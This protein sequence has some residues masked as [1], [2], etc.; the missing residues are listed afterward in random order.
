M[1]PQIFDNIKNLRELKNYTQQYMAEK[2]SITQAGYNKI[3]KGKTRLTFDKL[4]EISEIL[5]VNIVDTIS[6]DSQ[7]YFNSSNKV[8][9]NKN[10]SINIST[11]SKKEI[12]LYEDKI[13]LLKKLLTRVDCE[14]HSYKEKFGNNSCF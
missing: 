8:T 5:E 4:I 3:E 1:K 7:K 6:F 10:G 11:Q 13:F 9:G 14:L 2:L 12:K